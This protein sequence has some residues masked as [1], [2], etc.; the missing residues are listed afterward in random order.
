MSKINVELKNKL[1]MNQKNVTFSA[2]PHQVEVYIPYTPMHKRKST[3]QNKI[4]IKMTRRGKRVKSRNF[5]FH[6][7]EKTYSTR[8]FRFT[9]YKNVIFMVPVLNKKN[10]IEK[11]SAIYTLNP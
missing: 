7:K 6:N 11:A 9:K 4:E 1:Y 2:I 3:G 5:C 10:T 8:E